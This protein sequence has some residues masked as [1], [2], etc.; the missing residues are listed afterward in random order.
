MTGWTQSS[1]FPTTPGAFDT[2]YN[3][4]SADAF[5]VRLNAA[6][7]ALDYATF[8][9][10]SEWDGG[11]AIAWTPPAALRDGYTS[12]SD[13]PTT[14]GAFDP[15]FNGGAHDAFVVR[16]NAAGSALDYAT[17]LGGSG[18]TTATPWR[19]TPPAAPP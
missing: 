17:F 6:G 16:L 8:L 19:W 14:P 15:S 13:F 3:G 1:D 9:G 7:S 12:S 5:V 4:G 18:G 10:G 11:D 2:S